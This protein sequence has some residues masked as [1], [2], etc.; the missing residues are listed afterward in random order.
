MSENVVVRTRIDGHI[1]AEAALV[2]DSM[3]LTMSEAFRI[4]LTRV[5]ADKALPFSPLDPNNE[6]IEAMTESRSGNLK[7]FDSIAALMEDLNAKD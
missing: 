5:A 1:K 2:L 7:S 4:F 3:G 6:T